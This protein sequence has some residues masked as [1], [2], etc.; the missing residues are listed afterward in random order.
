[1]KLPSSTSQLTL[2]PQVTI[3]VT[4]SHIEVGGVAV[5]NI[6][7]GEIVEPLDKDGK[8]GPLYDR[9]RSLKA[10]RAAAKRGDLGDGSLVLVLADKDTD[11][12]TVTR[13]LKTAGFAGFVNVRFGVIAR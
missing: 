8:V 13:V 11:S 1:M 5:S 10:S 7:Q 6:Q 9:L 4:A 2:T 12:Q 3:T